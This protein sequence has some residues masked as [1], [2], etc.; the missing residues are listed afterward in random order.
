MNIFNLPIFGFNGRNYAFNRYLD[1]HRVSYKALKESVK[2]AFDTTDT[3]I[4]NSWRN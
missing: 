4:I 3:E 1:C 2:W